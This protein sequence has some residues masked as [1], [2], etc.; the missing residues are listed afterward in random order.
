MN[1]NELFFYLRGF[2]ENVSEPSV[3]QIQA[4]RNEILRTK[5]VEP[6]LIPVEVV[7]P[8]VRTASHSDC[9]CKK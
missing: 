9:N 7:N 3:P 8:T 5:P 1:A 4:L 6:Q 2:F